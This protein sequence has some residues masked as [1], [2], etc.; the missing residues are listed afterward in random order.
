M[1]PDFTIKIYGPPGT[2]KSQTL[3]GFV[4]EEVRNGT[5]PELVAYIAFGHDAIREA[6]RRAFGALNRLGPG[7]D[8]LPLFRTFHSLAYKLLGLGA[9]ERWR[10]RSDHQKTFCDW[11]GLH[12]SPT[13]SFEIDED[14]SR[15]PF[16]NFVFKADEW[17]TNNLLP[18]SR[19]DELAR[20]YDGPTHDLA[21]YI[22]RWRAYKQKLNRGEFHDVL[23]RCRAQQ[24]RFPA[25]A[26]IVDEFQDVNPL[27][28]ALYQQWAAQVERVYIAGDDDQTIFGFQ[29]ARASLF[30]N[31]HSDETRILG[32]THRLPGEI[33]AYGQRVI[34]NVRVRQPKTV[35]ACTCHACNLRR[36]PTPSEGRVLVLERPMIDTLLRHVDQDE[37]F[38][39][40]RTRRK[41]SSFCA[42][43]TR[44][45]IPYHS[46]RGPDSDGELWD[47]RLIR[48]KQLH[49][50]I[51]NPS[52]SLRYADAREA[53]SFMEEAAPGGT[54]GYVLKEKLAEL[55]RLPQTIGQTWPITGLGED[56]SQWTWSMLR[57]YIHRAPRLD[58]LAHAVGARA[59]QVDAFDAHLRHAP[60]WPITLSSGLWTGTIHASKGLQARTVVLLADTSKLNNTRVHTRE[61]DHDSEHRL[62]YVGATRAMRRLIIARPYQGAA[63]F[64][65]PMGAA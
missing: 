1:A 7:T 18:L 59:D 33:H 47:R 55:T 39:L 60:D 56:M 62:F 12:Y 10:I 31:A 48:A 54:S 3:L 63:Y 16:G 11:Y 43:L 20:T 42:A 8:D 53:L 40:A 17:L 26:L 46:L 57:R 38:I 51:R 4:E 13:A 34:S 35:E 23:E 24:P 50:L 61:E 45:G 6:R 32:Q 5:P 28:H 36:G 65:L 58:D 14:V 9:I 25:V 49:D 15:L 22:D 2:G 30:L 64:P 27:Q 44:A 21:V 29:G 37:T 52:A 19:I 41:L